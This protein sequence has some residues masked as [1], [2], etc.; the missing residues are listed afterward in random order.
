MK[1]LLIDKCKSSE[2]VYSVDSLSLAKH[3]L[4]DLVEQYKQAKETNIILT[5]VDA[6]TQKVL[7]KEVL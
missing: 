3:C 6:A 7:I 2:I 4:D 5:I 1:Y